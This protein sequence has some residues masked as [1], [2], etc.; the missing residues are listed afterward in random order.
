MK[1]FWLPDVHDRH[2]P[3]FEIWLQSPCSAV[4]SEVKYRKNYLILNALAKAGRNGLCTEKMAIFPSDR[5]GGPGRSKMAKRLNFTLSKR[6]LGL[7]LLSR[8]T[9]AQGLSIPPGM[10][11]CRT[12][13]GQNP[14]APSVGLR[15]SPQLPFLGSQLSRPHFPVPSRLGRLPNPLLA[16]FCSSYILLLALLLR[17]EH[18]ELEN[19]VRQL[20]APALRR[21][22]LYY[23]HLTVPNL[24]YE[25]LT[26]VFFLKHC[27]CARKSHTVR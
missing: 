6:F 2:A 27:R 21:S 12:R 20:H 22:S 13:W 10:D 15:K 11:G 8:N 5:R 16:L 4:Q 18:L 26:H 7:S 25:H 14:A 17:S 24:S 23:C 9:I 3:K 1:K 19:R